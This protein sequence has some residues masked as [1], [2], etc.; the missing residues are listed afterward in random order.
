MKLFE[1]VDRRGRGVYTD[2]YAKRQPKHKAALDAKR[3]AILTAGEPGTSVGGELPPNMF[4]GPVKYEDRFYPHTWKWTVNCGIKMR[5]LACKGPI[6]DD[7]E[8]TILV[9]VI[10]V[11]DK[12]PRGCFQ[13]AEDRRR[14]IIADPSR[15]RRIYGDDDEQAD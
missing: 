7:A 9:P 12:Y 2:W 4:R 1:Y 13:D 3:D 6:D 8:W 15:R 14:E 11:G 5:P 10:E